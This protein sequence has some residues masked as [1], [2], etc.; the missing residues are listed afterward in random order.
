MRILLRTL[1]CLSPVVWLGAE[2]F[3]A[4]LAKRRLIQG[5]PAPDKGEDA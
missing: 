1:L 4:V 2:V 3:F 5:I